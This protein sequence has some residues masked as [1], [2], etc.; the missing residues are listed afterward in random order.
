MSVL[1]TF[2]GQGSQRAGMLHALPAHNEIARTIEEAGDALGFDIRSI[3]DAASLRSTVA[4][5]LCLLIAGVGQARALQTHG[6]VPDMVSGL[7]IG[8][9]PAAVVAGAL[10]FSDALRLVALRGQL[11][12]QAY[13]CGFG[14][15][16]IVGL[17]QRPLERLIAQVNSE[18]GPV[19][20]A[21][22]NAETQ[23]VVSGSEVSINQLAEAAKRQ[24][25]QRC[26]RLDGAVP[27]HCALLNAPAARLAD[28]FTDVEVRA[29]RVT[30]LSSSAAR[31]LFDGAQI[32][33][34][35]AG[36]MAHPVRWHDT[37]R[38]AW[39]RGARLAI[40]MPPANVLTRLASP[41]F[42]DGL[43]VSGSDTSLPDLSA[44]INRERVRAAR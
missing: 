40:E 35:L 9:Y 22:I 32:A 44:L 18:V 10:G 29:P 7:S 24:G 17:T 25:A 12:E 4:V 30:Y 38:L 37:M 33:A 2:P 27:S 15:L 8:E 5:Q 23:M 13:P 41:I 34:D 19:F 42:T 39:E 14:M 21:N 3:D 1:F 31:P 36:N 43:A 11:M 20:L 6:H 26:E 16:A 28:A